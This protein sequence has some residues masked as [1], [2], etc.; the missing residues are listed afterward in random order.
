MTE[1]P[2]CQPEDELGVRTIETPHH[3]WK[4]TRVKALEAEKEALVQVLRD[5]RETLGEGFHTAFRKGSDC[6]EA[7]KIHKLIADMPSEEWEHVVNF[8][9][10]YITEALRVT[11]L[12]GKEGGVPSGA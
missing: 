7:G 5:T 10:H 12:A 2:T 3:C 9:L 11:A 6:V 8:A 4:G 1:T